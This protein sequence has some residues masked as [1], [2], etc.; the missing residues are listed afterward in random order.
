M[1]KGASLLMLMAG[2]TLVGHAHYRYQLVYPLQHCD[3]P[4]TDMEMALCRSDPSEYDLMLPG[5]ALIGFAG[6]GVQLSNIHIS[7]LFPEARALVTCFIVGALQM[8]FFIFTI[9]AFL[10]DHYGLTKQA[11]FQGYTYVLFATLVCC[12]IMDPDTPFQPIEMDETKAPTPNQ[13]E[14]LSPIRLPSVFREEESS[15]LMST[16]EIS[17]YRTR[18]ASSFGGRRIARAESVVFMTG[19][20]QNRSFKTQVLSIAFILLTLYFSVCALWCNFFLGSVTAQLRERAELSSSQVSSLIGDLGVILPSSVVFIPL[21]GYL[22]EAWGYTGVT[23][24]CTATAL[25]FTA[26]FQSSATSLL[27]ASFVLYTLFR[28]ILFSLL[29]AS[30]GQTFGF[31]HFGVLSG[32]TFVVAALIGLLQTPLTEIGDFGVVSYIQVRAYD[33]EMNW[34]GADGHTLCC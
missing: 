4:L 23:V 19:D 31:Q 11:I 6:P 8:S 3:T 32:I 30:L 17:K 15:L 7:S 28:T 26:L 5:M 29:F 25:L 13:H 10:Y 18:R 24:L 21:V 2:A 12:L 33:R 16:P 20:L 9:F 14:L 27:V 22:L 1:T 34:P